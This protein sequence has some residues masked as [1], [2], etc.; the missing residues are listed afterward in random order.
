[1]NAPGN[2]DLRARM[3]WAA[4][5]ALNGMTAYGKIAGDWGV[6]ALG[7]VISFLYD[8]PH[9]ATLSIAYP[10]WLK[11][12]KV[13]LHGRIAE[14]GNHLFNDPDADQTIN[15]LESFFKSLGSPV[16]LTDIG[17]GEKEAA[18]VLR[19][20]NRNRASGFNHLLNDALREEMVNH[21][22]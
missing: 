6:H 16:R 7:H 21:M 17:L 1:M 15:R 22:L 19:L 9:G 3:M 20:A 2:Y 14:L 12:L 5:N 4:T 13:K 8:T 10:A 11:G 18:E